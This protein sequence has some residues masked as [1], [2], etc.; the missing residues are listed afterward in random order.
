MIATIILAA[1]QSRRMGRAKLLIKYRGKSLLKIA[2]DKALQV[3]GISYLV[4]GAKQEYLNEIKNS[5]VIALNN[6]NWNEGLASSLRLGVA[7]LDKNVRAALIILPDQPLVEVKH[8]Q[9]LIKL[10]DATNKNLVYSK[11]QETLGVPAI[12]G[13]DLFAQVS[14]I[15]GDKGARVL[16]ANNEF[17]WLLLEHYLDIDRP[18]DLS[19]ILQ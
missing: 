19:N 6:P 16:A 3:S 10:F 15:T 18:E 12:I 4:V 2:I 14:K 5:E 1:G 9:K 7:S 13:R 17:E 8:L 11:Y